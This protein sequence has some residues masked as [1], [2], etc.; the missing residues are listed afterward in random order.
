VPYENQGSGVMR[1][2]KDDKGDESKQLLHAAFLEYDNNNY[3]GA[4]EIFDKISVNDENKIQVWMYGGNAYLHEGQVE[5]AKIMFQNIIDDD[6]G[7]VIH[8]KWYL[9]LCYV[10]NEEFQEAKPILE[11]IRDRGKYKDE[12]AAEILSKL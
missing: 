11:E 3:A 7:F 5:K 2:E 8:A 1:G 10:K 6:A 9:S 4:A 12:E